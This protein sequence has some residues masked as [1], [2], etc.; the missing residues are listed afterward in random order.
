MNG[1]KYVRS[2]NINH[3]ERF[4]EYEYNSDV[5]P[6][7]MNIW[8]LPQFQPYLTAIFIWWFSPTFWT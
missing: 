4:H 2:L 3:P 5:L 1:G 6:E 8:T 7:F